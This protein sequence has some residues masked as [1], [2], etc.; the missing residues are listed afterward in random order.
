[1]NNKDLASMIIL[2]VG[3]KENVD[4]LT[5]CATRL[6]FRLKDTKIAQKDELKKMNGVM[7]VVESGGEFQVVIGS[8]VDNVYNVIMSSNTFGPSNEELSSAEKSKPLDKLFNIISGTFTP[9][10][11][12]IVGSGMLKALLIIL[13]S[14]GWVT[15]E[16]GAYAIWSAAS[17]AVFYFLPILVAVTLAMKLKANPYVA[18]IIAA[19]LMEPNFT[20]L[21]PKNESIDFLGIPVILVDYASQIFPV[22]ISI[23]V[24]SVFE[25]WLKKITPQTVRLFLVPMLS[26]T[27]IVPVTALVF[28]PFG[29]YVGNGIASVIS[30]LMDTSGILSGAVIGAGFTFMVVL[31]LHWGLFPIVMANFA[32]SGYDSILAMTAAANMAQIGVALGVYFKTKNRDLKQVAGPGTLSGILAGVTEPIVYGII[33]R[34]KRTIPIVIIAG[35]VGGAINGFFG[36]RMYGFVLTNIFS[37]SAFSPLVP[38]LISF[39]IT[40]V[41]ATVLVMLFGYENK[42]ATIAT[43]TVNNVGSTESE[44]LSQH[45][46]IVTGTLS[47]PALSEELVVSP[48][49]G[50]IVPLTDVPDEVFSTEAMGEGIA[51]KP[52]EGKLYSPVDGIVSR[53]FP[54]LHALVITT[55]TGAEL[56][57]HI[58]LNTV[59]L[60]GQHFTSRIQENARVSQGELLLEFDIEAIKASG[61]TVVT[62][63]VVTNTSEF[64]TIEVLKDT[65]SV[66]QGN[67][68]LFIQ[69]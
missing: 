66:E 50:K 54:T 17:N 46:E 5:H 49:A 44:H 21:M 41:L 4:S 38:V 13:S 8:N 61:Y 3:G 63:I 68:I 43:D 27:I 29:V 57:I 10:L 20:S 45:T 64:D 18:A 42:K 52:G 55:N 33:L 24:F 25:R 7:T 22:F 32:A 37:V 59:K 39:V 48:L 14:L 34:Y 15:A 47:E 36:A 31:G 60:K 9:L 40:I 67:P 1:M 19:A 12:A 62:P 51:I 69:H 35:A 23:F 16:D 30:M 58:G 6:R 56:L 26:I 28:G 2:K 53:V 11:P 65:G